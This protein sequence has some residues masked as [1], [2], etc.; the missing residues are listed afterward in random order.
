MIVRAR[1]GNARTGNNQR[2]LRALSDDRLDL[3]KK[4]ANTLLYIQSNIRHLYIA[5]RDKHILH[6]FGL[7]R[8][9]RANNDDMNSIFTQM[10]KIKTEIED[11]R[12]K[13]M[14]TAT[15]HV[16]NFHKLIL[17][18]EQMINCRAK[19]NFY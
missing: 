12:A 18:R 3:Y 11:L 7:E 19:I 2:L 15:F 13:Q 17:N 5:V 4:I 14:N 9:I 1:I 16:R 10:E 8:D 6:K